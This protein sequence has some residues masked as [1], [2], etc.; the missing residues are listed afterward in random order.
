MNYGDF[1]NKVDESNKAIELKLQGEITRIGSITPDA[2]NGFLLAEALGYYGNQGFEMTLDINSFGGNIVASM[3]VISQVKKHKVNTHISGVAFSSAGLISMAGSKRTMNDYSQLMIHSANIPDATELS[4]SE[5]AGI[6]AFNNS[7]TTIITNSSNIDSD[8]IKGMLAKDTFID[9]SQAIEMGLVDEV[10]ETGNKALDM[11]LSIENIYVNAYQLNKIEKKK[12]DF[13]NKYNDAL[14]EKAE[15][16]GRLSEV[17]NKYKELATELDTLK[18]V[19]NALNE[20]KEELEK[21][22]LAVV[23]A[24]AKAYLVSKNMTLEGKGLDMFINAYR[25]D[26]E[27]AKELF[28][29]VKVTP[30]VDINNFIEGAEGKSKTEM[31]NYYLNDPKGQEELEKMGENEATATKYNNLHEEIRMAIQNGEIK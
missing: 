16:E 4:E 6:E 29:S 19:N 14:K 17:D 11:S 13:E 22:L 9:S 12:M 23:D 25:E 28:A 10:I 8:R 7:I 24:E 3:S 20:K 15:L 30:A 26:K 5:K 27:T 31:L 2:T 1:I 21:E 18:E